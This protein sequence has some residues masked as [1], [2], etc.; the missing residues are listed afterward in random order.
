MAHQ[1]RANGRKAVDHPIASQIS[2]SQET[3]FVGRGRELAVIEQHFQNPDCHLL[4][5]IGLG[6][7]GKTRIAW[8]AASRMADNFAHG[9]YFVSLAAIATPDLI[10]PAIAASVGFNFQSGELPQTQL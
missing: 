1:E 3:A 4:N 2:R 9:V 5:L 10:V 6:G 8:E 7:V